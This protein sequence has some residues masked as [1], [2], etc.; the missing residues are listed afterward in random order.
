MILSK[1]VQFYNQLCALT[2]DNA[3]QSTDKDLQNI[4]QI[5]KYSELETLRTDV[6]NSFDRFESEFN[7]FK[8]T[9]K[10][11]IREEERPYLQ[12]SYKIYE[13]LQANK[14]RWFDM[15]LP[16]HRPNYLKDQYEIREKNIQIQVETTLK[17]REDVS[18][19]AQDYIKNRIIFYSSWQKT[20]MILHPGQQPWVKD[21]V[22]NDPL[23][24]VDESYDFLKPS[25]EQFNELYQRRLRPYTIRE[26]QDQDILWQLPNNQFGVIVAYNYFDHRPF[27]VIR[28]YLTEIYDKLRTGGTLLMTYNDCDRWQG[29]A[30]VENKVALYTPGFLIQDFAKSL[31]FEETV[32]WHE[33]GPWTWVE[34][35]KPG[36]WESLRGG[37]ALA[38]ILPKPVAKSK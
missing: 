2:A 13:Q 10:N 28:R 20:T 32:A 30:A 9:I 3:K 23:Y 4:I 25:I 29:V 14:Y 19:T 35:R 24:L 5:S 12:D 36:E 11:Q 1:L 38:K 27:E 22:S 34:L 7:Q 21:L 6:L 18:E 31:G 17:T 15:A 33:N 37:Q 16:E 26:D 8:E